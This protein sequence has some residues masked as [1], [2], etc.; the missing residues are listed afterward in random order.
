GSGVTGESSLTD[1]GIA[2]ARSHFIDFVR[3]CGPLPGLRI[4]KQP[5]GVLPV[6]SLAEWRPRAG[7]EM[8]F[9]RDSNL[10]DLLTK[11]RKI[12]RRNFQEVPRLGRTDEVDG[13]G[14]DK[15]L[16]EVLSMDGL[17]STFSI[18]QLMGRHYLDNL[19]VFLSADFFLDIWEAELPEIPP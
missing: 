8:E 10:Q 12:W 17:S 5:Y 13:S 11:L 1:E 18:R 3:A 6:T 19:L 9:K 14:L 15:D 4:G 2:W 16:A 7:Q